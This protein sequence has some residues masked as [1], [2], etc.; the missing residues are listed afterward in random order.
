[1]PMRAGRAFRPVLSLNNGRT[2][3]SAEF[4]S[5]GAGVLIGLVYALL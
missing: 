4:I 2:A 3:M 5:L 1:M